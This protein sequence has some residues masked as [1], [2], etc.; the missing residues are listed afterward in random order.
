MI[1][2]DI[3]F[4]LIGN[5]LVLWFFL[6]KNLGGF[7]ILDLDCFGEKLKDFCLEDLNGEGIFVFLCFLLRDKLCIC[8]FGDDE[9][10]G[11]LGLGELF[12]NE[13]VVV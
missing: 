1:V 8:F 11:L 4:G 12:D 7:E 5:L 2:D 3:K 9:I 13:F 6:L 10:F